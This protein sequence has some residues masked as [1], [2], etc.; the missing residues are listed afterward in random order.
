MLS[1]IILENLYF[2]CFPNYEYQEALQ[3]HQNYS[4]RRY[5]FFQQEIRNFHKQLYPKEH[6]Q[7]FYKKYLVLRRSFQEDSFNARRVSGQSLNLHVY[8][9]C[10]YDIYYVM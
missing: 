6:F 4:I 3:I 2:Q 10:I 1:Q 8:S 9:L 5:L 7:I